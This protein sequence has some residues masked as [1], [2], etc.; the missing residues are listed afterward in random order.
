MLHM[1]GHLALTKGMNMATF[2]RC[3]IQTLLVVAVTFSGDGSAWKVDGRAQ[4]LVGK[5]LAIPL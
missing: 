5:G 2:Y 4:A 3:K 1:E